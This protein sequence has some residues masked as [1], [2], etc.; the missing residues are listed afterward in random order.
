M[1]SPSSF[2]DMTPSGILVNK[3]TSDLGVIDTSLNLILIDSLEGF[4]LYFVA[5]AY[6]CKLCLWMI[7]PIIV[8]FSSVIYFYFYSR[9][10]IISCKQMDIQYKN[11]IFQ[12][13]SESINGLTQI[14]ICG[15]RMSKIQK[16]SEILNQ[17]IKTEL[18][19]EATSR[20]F[21]FYLAIFSLIL[22]TVGMIIGVVQS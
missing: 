10:V 14:R 22:M 11:P 21:I 19:C 4:A 16:F 13:Y 7:I 18:T 9:P 3:F 6:L 12:F 8:I 15:R 2:F 5:F 17:S 20:G 1:R